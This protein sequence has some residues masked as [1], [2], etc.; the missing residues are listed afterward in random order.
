MMMIAHTGT[1]DNSIWIP[2]PAYGLTIYKNQQRRA[3]FQNSL[4]ACEAASGP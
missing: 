2:A 1:P 3:E 4:N